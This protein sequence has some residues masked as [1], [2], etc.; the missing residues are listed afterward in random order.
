MPEPMGPPELPEGGDPDSTTE[1]ADRQFLPYGPGPY[2]PGPYRGDPYGGDPYG[3]YGP[4]PTA[5]PGVPVD[6][7]GRPMAAWWKRV[8]AYLID[9]VFLNIVVSLVLGFVGTGS[10]KGTSQAVDLGLAAVIGLGYFAFLDGSRRGQTVGKAL[11]GIAT[12]DIRTGGPI[13][14]WRGLVRRFIFDVLFLAF[15]VP[16]VLNVLSPLWDRH[17]QAWHEKLGQTC[18]V[19]VR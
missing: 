3:A 8:L 5:K 10:G 7:L 19:D 18:V 16:G 12:R 15:L 13:G 4:H 2:G 17:R 9:I 6:P 1:P 14:A 11:L